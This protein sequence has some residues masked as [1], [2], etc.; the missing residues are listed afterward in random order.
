MALKTTINKII[1]TSI[2]TQV[3]PGAV[4]LVAKGDTI[5]Y[6]HAYGATMYE[7]DGSVPVHLDTIYDIASLTKVFTATAALRLVDAGMLDL[8]APIQTYLPDV[9]AP[10]IT[11]L[12]LL[13]HTSGLDIRLSSLRELDGEGL[14]DVVYQTEPCYPPGT[15]VA[16]T[17]VNS[18]L[19]GEI[20]RHLVDTT[21]DQAIERLV[22][23]PLGLSDT[24]FCPPLALQS[25]IAPTEIDPDWR[26]QLVH[27]SVHDESTH[28]L[29]GVAGHAGLFSTASDLYRFCQVWLADGQHDECVGRSQILDS[30][31]LCRET[32][33]LAC[34]NH[35]PGLALSCGLGWMLDRPNFMG[36]AP[37]GSFGHTGFTGPAMVIVPHYH[38]IVVVLCNRV[39]PRRSTPDHHAVIASIVETAIEYCKSSK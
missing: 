7:D 32:K 38:L 13:T 22:L 4:V 34:T 10:N 6:H 8:Y 9:Q 17:N 23:T 28:A 20:V 3:F 25:R 5:L 19:L 37:E 35:T 15:V 29:G 39:Y 24:C 12:H 31:F 16:Y 2:D 14:L 33:A 27:G 36:N 18:L 21:L 26:G 11:V 1:D 30:A